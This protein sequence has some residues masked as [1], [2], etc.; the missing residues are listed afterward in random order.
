M[1]Q[2]GTYSSPPLL[3]FRFYKLG[4]WE[5]F[6]ARSGTFTIT[7]P[8]WIASIYIAFYGPQS[9]NERVALMLVHGDEIPTVY[10][11][12]GLNGR[13][14]WPD[15]LKSSFPSVKMLGKTEQQS[16]T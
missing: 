7:E 2:P 8:L 10:E 9:V 6:G 4:G 13:A 14:D 16:Y 11:P 1:L 5:P 15:G 3:T 12:Y